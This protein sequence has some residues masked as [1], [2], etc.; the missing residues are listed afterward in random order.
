MYLGL[1]YFDGKW[2][3]KSVVMYAAQAVVSC[4]REEKAKKNKNSMR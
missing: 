3:Y 2:I 4:G 1:I